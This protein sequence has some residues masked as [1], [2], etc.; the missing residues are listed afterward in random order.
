M[1]RAFGARYSHPTTPRD[2]QRRGAG[3][4]VAS[5]LISTRL[6]LSTRSEAG[7][8]FRTA[9]RN[10]KAPLHSFRPTWKRVETSLDPAGTVP[11]PDG[12]VIGCEQLEAANVSLLQT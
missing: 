8:G 2:L 12:L 3:T 10:Q 6:V 11:A 4:R 9:A 1:S 7:R 5:R